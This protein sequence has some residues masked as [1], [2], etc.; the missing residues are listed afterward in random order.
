MKSP[1]NGWRRIGIVAATLWLLAGI[2]VCIIERW[3][4]AD[5]FFV[6]QVVQVSP[7]LTITIA[8]EEEFKTRL[9]LEREQEIL[10]MGK[11]SIP[12]HA[13]QSPRIAVIHWLRLGMFALIPFLVW[14]AGEIA[15]LI[16]AW[17]RRGFAGKGT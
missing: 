14:F 1:L 4:N 8:E 11:S 5:G 12:E 13:S 16:V 6:S 10:T 2:G 15:V 17:V 3:S 9:K 7:D